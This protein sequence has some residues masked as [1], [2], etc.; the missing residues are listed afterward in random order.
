MWMDRLAK[1]FS[2]VVALLFVLLCALG[3]LNNYTPV[4]FWDMWGGNV[5][6]YTRLLDGDLGAWWEQHVSHRVLL[7][8]VL[9]F[10]DNALVGGNNTLLLT[11]H[12]VLLALIA[13][14]FFLVLRLDDSFSLRRTADFAVLMLV[15]AIS[16]SWIQ[17]RNITWP[18]Q[19]QMFLA[20][21][22]PAAAFLLLHRAA[23]PE[24]SS[25]SAMRLF[26]LSLVVG[27]ASAFTM[28][29]GIFAL[30]LMVVLGLAYRL[31]IWKVG[32]TVLLAIA[33][34]AI[35]YTGYRRPDLEQPL[36]ETILADPVGIF[37]FA[38]TLLGAPLHYIAN[39]GPMAVALAG[40]IVIAAGFAI[41]SAFLISKRETR[42]IG[43]FFLAVL[44]YVGATMLGIAASRAEIEEPIQSRYMTNTLFAWSVFA[45]MLWYTL[46]ALRWRGVLSS[47]ALLLPLLLLTYQVKALDRV[48]YPRYNEMV[49]VLALELGVPDE[50][51]MLFL[52]P[53]MDRLFTV[54]ERAR[55]LDTSIFGADLYRGLREK[56]GGQASLA[57]TET[58][59][60]DLTQVSIGPVPGDPSHLKFAGVLFSPQMVEYPDR[61]E[62]VSEDRNIAGFAVT[63]AAVYWPGREAL[64]HATWVGGYSRTDGQG[65]RLV[66]ESDT[67]SCHFDPSELA[68]Q[69]A[70]Q[71]G[72]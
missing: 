72:G 23:E 61:F 68:R 34:L 14:W 58:E 42:R 5:M 47:F 38:F 35:F 3:I 9:F 45:V 12:F 22:V 40:G 15:I 11:A 2:A 31:P 64:S 59:T 70:A 39:G 53:W 33:M 8:K 44:I 37:S 46:T 56:V 32:A 26:A 51:Q 54:S 29:N 19:A 36:T 69:A 30:P 27:F 1:L 60:C 13:F 41:M 57:V 7:T 6:F 18:F 24:R 65:A 62:V 50:E 48:L 20:N 49:G 4:P 16:F 52:F 63:D 43:F 25:S 66:L 67:Y 71:S 21:L 17:W 28:K 10:A 55:E